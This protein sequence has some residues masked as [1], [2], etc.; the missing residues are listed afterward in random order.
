MGSGAAGQAS[1]S[2][3]AYAGAVKP[4]IDEACEG[5][6]ERLLNGAGRSSLPGG[7]KLLNGGKK[8]R[9][10]L[11]CLVAQT[12]GGRLED[13]LLAASAIE[14]IQTATLL[15]DDYVDQHETRRGAPALWTLEGSRRA[16][17]LGDV[18][19]SSAIAV[20][21]E[22]GQAA[23]I[24]VSQAI[25]EMSSGAFQEPMEPAEF[26][27]GVESGEIGPGLYEK[28]IRL[29]TGVLFGAACSLGALCAGAE[30]QRVEAWKLYG[31][32]IG[33]AFQIADDLTDLTNWLCGKAPE[34]WGNAALAPALLHFGCCGESKEG[35]ESA[36][37]GMRLEIKRRLSLAVREVEPQLAESRMEEL[38]RA[39]PFDLLDWFMETEAAP[40]GR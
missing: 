14:L 31:E 35:I 23:G 4:L 26:L 34:P 37:T 16:V 25:A 18:L 11:A 32:R 33:E 10:A 2:F 3:R 17:L 1:L 40:S 38:A 29:K 20:M 36:A 9:G 22:R 6:L 27:A 12:L 15:H 30:G 21:G 13:A 19:F 7:P 8:I 39:A 5:Y 28:I 24:A